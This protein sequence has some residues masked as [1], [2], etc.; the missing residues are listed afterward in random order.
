MKVTLDREGKN[1][2]RVGLE[3]EADRAT[4]AYEVTC[5]DLSNQ[6][7]IPGF[8]KG[9]A[10][11]NIIE[12]RFGRDAIKQEALE[13]MLPEL[14]QQVISDKKLD[15]IT[16]PEIVECNFELGE[17]LKLSAKFEVR[18]EVELG[19]YKGVKADVPEAKTPDDSLDKTLEGIAEQNATVTKIDPRKVKMGDH[20]LLD[21][22]CFVEDKPVEGGK[23]ENLPLELKEGAFVEGFCEQVVGKKPEEKFEVEV[24]FPK[25]YRNEALAGK[26]A[27]FKVNL[28]ELREKE[29]P[30]IDDE[31]AAKVGHASLDELKKTI[32]EKVKEE[33]KFE[34]E[35][36]AQRAVVE[37]VVENSKLDIPESMIDREFELL[38]NQ[39]RMQFEQ[40][41]Q[42][43]DEFQKMDDFKALEESK[44]D[45]ASQRVLHSLVLGAVVRAEDMV[46]QEEEL[47]AYL[48]QYAMQ[49]QIPPDK[50]SEMFQ[51][52]YVM[53]QISEDVLT[54]KV[55]DFLV[56]N[57]EINYVPDTEDSDNSD[58]GKANSSKKAPAKS[59][60]ETKAK[61]DK[62]KEKAPKKTKKATKSEKTAKAE[63]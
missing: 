4:R 39:I 17:P 62:D 16:R 5:R 20:V 61:T 33:V 15:I 8:R 10:P 22:E 25:D 58:D 2:V 11:R 43:W 46:V 14:L 23:A 19:E 47:T 48:N 60:K 38:M 29:V 49:N 45:E 41:G 32:E 52:E 40:G 13:R 31:L 55:V 27:K 28:R 21:F 1:V 50:Y 53:R 12:K 59:K 30:P 56:E 7:E 57:A 18:P 51:D 3:V 6:V 35:A 44:K 63:Q 37:A 26:P 36:R 34:N 24:T 9:K 54:G 42:S